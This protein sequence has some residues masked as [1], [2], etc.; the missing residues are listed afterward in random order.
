MR[1]IDVLAS[2]RLAAV[3]IAAL[4][5]ACLLGGVSDALFSPWVMAALLGAL[6]VNT[7]V[8]T[9]RMIPS[10]RTGG[11]TELALDGTLAPGGAESA[12]ERAHE[13]L[14]AL[15]YRVRASEADGGFAVD[16]KRGLPA[17]WALVAF[18]AALVALL[19]GIGVEVLARS[20]RVLVVA[21]GAFFEDRPESYVSVRDGALGGEYGRFY[22]R[23]RRVWQRG[24]ADWCELRVLHR[25]PG[26]KEHLR[27]SRVEPAALGG[28]TLRLRRTGPAPVLVLRKGDEIL[29]DA[30]VNVSADP[31]RGP[32]H[33]EVALAGG[34]KLLLAPQA[35]G[36]AFTA[37]LVEQGRPILGGALRPGARLEG[38]GCWIEMPEVRRWA[39]V[40]IV[41]DPALVPVTASAALCVVSLAAYALM[42]GRSISVAVRPDG[43]VRVSG[44][45][46][47]FDPL[48]REEL[49]CVLQGLLERSAP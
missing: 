47:R 5:A 20:E 30:C 16:G 12:R 44:R 6:G 15:G 26:G 49:A 17:R 14:R 29:L 38:G 31:D 9:M 27:F 34:G 8:C 18:H 46:H 25:G 21:P 37:T 4:A 32:A 48:F 19:A 2:K 45:S 36:E 40:S 24:G 42:V 22:G 3:L 43:A 7:A 35:G 1:I 10:L 33:D 28:A 39:E 41:Q 23:V 11:G 13:L